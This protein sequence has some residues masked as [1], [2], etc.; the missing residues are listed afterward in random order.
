M[1]DNRNI[2][3]N[4]KEL[5]SIA[6]E[7]DIIVDKVIEKVKSYS[8]K[9]NTDMIYVAYRVAKAAHKGQMRKSGEPY[10]IHPVQIA[11]IASDRKSV[12]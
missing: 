11:Y 6:D 8:P 9:A 4:P 7:T 1:D 3:E 10:I 5:G 2:F 12:V